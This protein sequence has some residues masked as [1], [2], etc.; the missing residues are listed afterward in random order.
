MYHKPR[1]QAAD[2]CTPVAPSST[3][4][5]TPANEHTGSKHPYLATRVVNQPPLVFDFTVGHV[6]CATPLCVRHL[7]CLQA[8]AQQYIRHGARSLGEDPYT[9]AVCPVSKR[10]TPAQRVVE[11]ATR[12]SVLK[13]GLL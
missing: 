8:T 4:A 1:I 3:R 7:C 12:T 9:A 11:M 2:S 13:F 5:R 6:F 10:P